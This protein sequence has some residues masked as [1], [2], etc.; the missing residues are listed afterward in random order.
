MVVEAELG[1]GVAMLAADVGGVPDDF[2]VAA[3]MAFEH[4]FGG[5]HHLAIF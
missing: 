3:Q 2:L 1:D 4:L 5:L